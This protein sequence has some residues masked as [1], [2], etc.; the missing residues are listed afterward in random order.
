MP[1]VATYVLVGTPTL[2]PPPIRLSYHPAQ[3]FPYHLCHTRISAYLICTLLFCIST[4]S[5]LVSTISIIPAIYPKI[6]GAFC[7]AGSG[8]H[9]ARCL[10]NTPPLHTPPDD[11]LSPIADCLRLKAFL[12]PG[13][14]QS[15]PF[16]RRPLS[17]AGIRYQRGGGM[18]SYSGLPKIDSFERISNEIPFVNS[19][20]LFPPTLSFEL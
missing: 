20:P 7:T 2:P 6:S 5:L 15:G 19:F 8:C 17:S 9:L 1:Y 11:T 3:P 16:L 13:A 12:R 10:C 4:T 18:I 14:L